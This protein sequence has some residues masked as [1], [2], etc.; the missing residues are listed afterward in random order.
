MDTLILWLSGSVQ[1]AI[2][3]EFQPLHL[4]MLGDSHDRLK[5]CGGGKEEKDNL[6]LSNSKLFGS[7]PEITFRFLSFLSSGYNIRLWNTLAF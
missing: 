1:D 3:Q 2:H 7:A 6:L 5:D 4:L